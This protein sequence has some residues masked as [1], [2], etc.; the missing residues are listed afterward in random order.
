MRGDNLV[1]F[2][3][4]T[5]RSSS[6]GIGG[7]ENLTGG[8]TVLK[9]RVRAVPHDGE[10]NEALKIVQ[11]TFPLIAA[12]MFQSCADDRGRA[13]ASNGLRSAA[14]PQIISM[15]AARTMSPEPNK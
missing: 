9:V 1:L 6:D 8:R 10:A 5:P 7:I 13:T 3:G 11:T 12:S 14:T 2:L 15:M 4:L